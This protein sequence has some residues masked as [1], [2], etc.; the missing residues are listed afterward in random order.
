MGNAPMTEAAV[1]NVLVLLHGTVVKRDSANHHLGYAELLDNLA[2]WG[3]RRSDFDGIVEVEWGREPLSENPVP[4]T[5]LR[6]DQRLT[7]AEVTLHDRASFSTSKDRASMQNRLLSAFQEGLVPQ[8]TRLVTD[9]IKEDVLIYGI[10]DA[11]Y[12]ASPDGETAIRSTVYHQVL[13]GLDAFT[14]SSH[15]RLFIIAHSLGVTVAH[16]F[17]FGLF[18]PYHLPDFAAPE[19]TPEATRPDILRD[20]DEYRH[21]KRRFAFWR[22]AAQRGA[23]RH[24]DSEDLGPRLSV[25]GLITTGGQLALMMLRTQAMVDRMAAGETLDPT[26]LGLP[27]EGKPIWYNF[28]DVDDVLGF[29]CHR[30]YAVPTIMDFQ[31]NTGLLEKAHS[32]YW[33]SKVVIERI[34]DL[35]RAN[36][37][38]TPSA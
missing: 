10:A 34:A 17:L 20:G 6:E 16:D 5:E 13:D 18:A 28:Y 29:P 33:T 21:D 1:K 8:A 36:L 9:R 3:V 37:F 26:L 11:V 15:I 7:R 22:A 2:L 24:N 31:V 23:A 38:Q 35:L 4:A 12:Y 19:D 27:R 30:L 25:A 32:R 14:E